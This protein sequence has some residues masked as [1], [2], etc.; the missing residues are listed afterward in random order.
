MSHNPD[1]DHDGPQSDKQ[2]SHDEIEERLNKVLIE[3]AGLQDRIWDE[4][5]EQSKQSR[6]TPELEE[7]ARKV[8]DDVS[9]WIDQCTAA[10]ESPPVLLRRME[11]Q[12]SRLKKVL[13]L[14]GKGDGKSLQ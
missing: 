14:I 11:V 2:P 1:P 6:L 10:S 9:C 7:F 12:L 8:M 3:I 4:M 5:E 13:E